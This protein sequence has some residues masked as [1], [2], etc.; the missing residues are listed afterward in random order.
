MNTVTRLMIFFTLMIVATYVY[1]DAMQLY[2]CEQDDDTTDEQV[3]AIAAEWIKAARTMKGGENIEGY[4][5]FPIAAEAG[6]RDFVFVV[7]GPSFA[8]W[9]AF[10]DAYE[11]SPA[12]EVDDR[13]SEMADCTRSAI[14]ESHKVK[15]E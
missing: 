11:G 6:E 1:A 12:E 4:L 15:V 3:D 14:W 8:E 2:Y 7:V 13:F 10:T 5:R 9:G